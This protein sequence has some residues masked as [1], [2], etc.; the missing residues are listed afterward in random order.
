[1]RIKQNLRAA[2]RFPAM[3]LAGCFFLCLSCTGPSPY[4][5][6]NIRHER[7][8]VTASGAP[9]TCSHF[10][11]WDG[12]PCEWVDRC[13]GDICAGG[14]WNCEDSLGNWLCEDETCLD[15]EQ[16]FLEPELCL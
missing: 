3:A 8:G 10:C 12:P 9:C 16:R 15:D 14:Y 13:S 6:T 2:V 7:D 5:E 4:P 1:M 11:S